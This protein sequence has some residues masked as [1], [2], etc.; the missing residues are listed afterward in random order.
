MSRSVSGAS[1]TRRSDSKSTTSSGS[2]SED[3]DVDTGIG[4]KNTD[5]H[6]GGLHRLRHQQEH[7]IDV[8]VEGMEEGDV[9]EEEVR[10][11]GGV[12]PMSRVRWEEKQEEGCPV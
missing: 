11:F 12:R 4:D 5:S 7:N 2:A 8:D 3:V 1:F 9:D 10:R 6:R